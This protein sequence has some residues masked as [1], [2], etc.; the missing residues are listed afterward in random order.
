MVRTWADRVDQKK[1]SRIILKDNVKPVFY[2]FSST[3]SDEV[4][5]I[6]TVS[7]H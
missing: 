6:V 5:H 1:D 7:I 4:L 3:A 2:L